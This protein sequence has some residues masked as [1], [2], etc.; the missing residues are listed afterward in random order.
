MTQRNTGQIRMHNLVHLGVRSELKEI[1]ELHLDFGER[2]T[3]RD[4]KDE[5]RITEQRPV[6]DRRDE[7]VFSTFYDLKP[8]CPP[9]KADAEELL[10]ISNDRRKD[11][12]KRSWS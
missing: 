7:G 11:W 4:L 9:A 10:H 3:C 5:G 6:A 2:P 1:R 12:L 8:D